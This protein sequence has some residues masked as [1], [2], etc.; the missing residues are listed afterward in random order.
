MSNETN[1]NKTNYYLKI[2]HNKIYKKYSKNSTTKYDRLIINSILSNSR[3]RIVAQFKDF[4]LYGDY[5]EFLKRYYKYY[6]IGVRLIKISR[7][8]GKY[9]IIYPNYSPLIE[10]KYMRSN[11]IKKQ[12]VINK[13]ENNKKR[14][15]RNHY[16]KNINKEDNKDKDKIFFS[17]TIYD[18][19]LNES[20][21][22]MSLL[23]GVDGK[24]KTEKKNKFETEKEIE[25][26]N[27]IINNIQNTENKNKKSEDEEDIIILDKEDNEQNKIKNYTKPDIDRILNSGICT[28][29]KLNK[30]RNNIY[31][32][33]NLNNNS[34]SLFLRS[35]N[36]TASGTNSVI[37][38]IQNQKYFMEKYKRIKIKAE[39]NNDKIYKK[40]LV[41]NIKNNPSKENIND[42]RNSTEK[43]HDK[44]VYHRK[45]KST[46]I[47]NYLNKL[48]LPSNLSVINSL[49]FANET[50][51]N[52]QNKNP[53]KVSLYK[54]GIK[55]NNNKENNLKDSRTKII[56]LPKKMQANVLSTKD[57]KNK[58]NKMQ[59]NK[60][61]KYREKENIITKL[62]KSKNSAKKIEIPIITKKPVSYLIQKRNSPPN[63][64]N[65]MSGISFSNSNW[66]IT[67]STMCRNS[68]IMN[69]C[70]KPDSILK[71]F[72]L[73]ANLNGPYS[74]PKGI[75]K[76][77][78]NIGISAKNL[79]KE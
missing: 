57:I 68:I 51:A 1:I 76:D 46:I 11:V 61:P 67:N 6:E 29:T 54:K 73:N 64:R 47:G 59:M 56:N 36:S 58:N 74:K 50:F 28:N 53:I 48:D 37:N 43:V 78:K 5:C 9:S 25:D 23:F 65:H 63:A 38:T 3:C 24:N 49:K 62:T 72:Y 75:Y 35:T 79:F 12:L 17:D 14:N 44:I 26:L 19:I 70:R 21:S 30:K 22:F 42:N 15:L 60:T 32:M 39:V 69:S 10:S 52:N 45:V 55:K 27:K 34:N 31:Y 16:N 20:E 4:L 18:D 66:D 2:A 77:K 7:Y 71:S 40:I 41:N 33:N 8:F 13:I